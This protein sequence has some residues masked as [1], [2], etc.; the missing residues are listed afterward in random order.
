MY[1]R[2]ERFRKK[3]INQ[4]ASA[5]ESSHERNHLYGRRSGSRRNR[6]F[7][8]ADSRSEGLSGIRT[9]D[10]PVWLHW[11]IWMETFLWK[12]EK[13]LAAAHMERLGITHLSR[14]C[15]RELS[16][17]QQQRVLLARA[18]C[19]TR[20]MLLLDEPVSGLDP[21]AVQEM[22]GLL[23]ELNQK[24][25]ITIIMVSHD[26]QAAVTYA[27]HILHVSEEPRFFGTKEAYLESGIG[28]AY[29]SA[30]VPAQT[31]RERVPAANA[32]EHHLD[33][34][35]RSGSC[36]TEAGGEQHV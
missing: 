20:Y 5:F 15:Y 25:N 31:M 9:G 7:A 22:Y 32:P 11:E 29:L 35:V 21:A 27:S 13:E 4:S 12:K 6:V 10:R 23:A 33:P 34:K 14:R 2:G 19:A 28:R 3:H 18:L 30:A 16:G 24:E 36:F 1:C 26:V 17:G 8:A